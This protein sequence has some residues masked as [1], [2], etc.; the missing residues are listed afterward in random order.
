MEGT[1]IVGGGLG[2]AIGAAMGLTGAGG[3]I[4]AV[5]ALVFGLGIGIRQ[6][7]PIALLT[8]GT[9][10]ALGAVQGLLQGVV[11]YRAA[12]LLAA[13]GAAVAPTGMKLAHQLPSSWLNALFGTVMLVVAYRMFATSRRTTDTTD[14]VARICR[15]SERTGRLVWNTRT[16]AT[17]SGIGLAAGL[18]T[19]L[20]GVGGGFIIVPSLAYVSNLPMNSIV[21]TSLMTIAVLSGTAVATAWD[22]DLAI[23]GPTLSFLLMTLV[24]MFVGRL[25]SRK[26]STV[27][28]QR[29][30]A[31]ACL[32]VATMMLARGLG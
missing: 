21:G 10:A 19:G 17:L 12:L 6:A 4:F 18:A 3:G 16:A 26:V 2:L 7:A 22:H 8:V 5:P 27:I 9:A 32:G 24:G 30:F 11:R 28:L 15:V 14:Q 25:F 1:L 20:L 13:A 23:G 29:A 31:L